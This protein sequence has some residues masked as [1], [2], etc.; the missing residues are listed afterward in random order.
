MP[1]GGIG[2]CAPDNLVKAAA[3]YGSTAR[4]PMLWLYTQNDSFF[5]PALARRMVDAYD[6]A[7]GRAALR[8]LGPFGNDGHNMASSS[9]G[10]PMWSGAVADFLASLK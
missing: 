3:R 2:N 10:V 7:G 4:V 6:A 5:E 9:S 8:P 1:E